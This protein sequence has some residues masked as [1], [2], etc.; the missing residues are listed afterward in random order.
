MLHG[1]PLADGKRHYNLPR[2]SVHR[3]DI[4]EVYHRGFVAEMFQRHIGQIE[5]H[6]FHQQVGGDKHFGIFILHHGAVVA[7]TFERRAVH[8]FYPFGKMPD[9][10][11]LA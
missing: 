3:I 9:E 1:E 8:K 6:T 11:K 7:H 2:M 10:A 4:R 5:V